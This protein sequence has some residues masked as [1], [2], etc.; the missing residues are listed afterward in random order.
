MFE[1]E[2]KIALTPNEY[3]HLRSQLKAEYG[4]LRKTSCHDTYYQNPKKAYLRVRRRGGESTL[5]LKRR[6]TIR[7]IESNIELSWQILSPQKWQTLM[8][9]L[10]L[11]PSVQKSK[12]G[13]TLK[14]KDFHIELNHLRKLG[15]FLEIETIVREAG[16]VG[17]AKKALVSLFKKLGFQ[18]DRFEPKPYLELLKDV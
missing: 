2:A 7:G 13:L 8:K 3:R 11:E 9:K 14:Y 16:R 4:P 12:T 5:D 6:E 18:P 17:E 15:Y 10:E 1:V